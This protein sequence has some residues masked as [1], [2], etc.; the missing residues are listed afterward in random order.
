MGT[1]HN[2]NLDVAINY[3]KY[4]GTKNLTAAALQQEFYKLGCSFDVFSSDEQVWVSLSGLTENIEKATK[5]FEDLLANAQP[6]DDALKNVVSDILKK[7]DDTKLNKSEILYGGLYAYGKYGKTSPYTN[8]LSSDELKN[9]KSADL[10]SLINNVTSYQHRI[11]YYGSNTPSELSAM[12]NNLH[13]VPATIKPIPAPVKFTETDAN[14]N[15]YVIDY[16]MKQAEVI[17]LA[18]DGQYNKDNTS[19]ARIFNEYFGGGMSSVVFQEMRESKA[20]AYSV[21][22][23]YSSARKKQDYN[24]VFS[25]IGTQADKLP[26]AMAGMMDLI[27]NMPES[28]NNFKASKEAIIQ[29]IRSERITKSGILFN[30]EN[31]Q[32]LGLDYDIRKDIFNN[33]PN[34]KMNDIKSFEQTHLKNKQ[35]TVL[36]VG[37]KESLDMPTLEKY[38]KVTFLTLNDI[39]GY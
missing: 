21:Y 16:D 36:V 37:K 19:I 25:Y 31:A 8:I 26:E 6:N 7:R 9:L 17:L 14:T 11:L 35:Y 5:L 34:M 15:V 39:F 23:S 10:I 29:G 18:K 4:L 33:V 2:K 1:N 13:K 32:K 38:G 3:L 12:L 22:S 28:E 27:N 20:L 30:Y 24:Y